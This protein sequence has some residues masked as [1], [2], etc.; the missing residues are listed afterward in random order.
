M[1][2]KPALFSA[3]ALGKQLGISVNAVLRLYRDE[4]IDAE[5]HEGRLIRFDLEKVRAALA[6]RAKRNRQS[7]AAPS[8]LVPLI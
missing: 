3:N 7:I 1:K 2:T 6:K 5:I 8:D 4:V